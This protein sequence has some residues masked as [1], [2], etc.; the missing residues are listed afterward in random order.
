M[1]VQRLVWAYVYRYEHVTQFW[2]LMDENVCIRVT[3]GCKVW[4]WIH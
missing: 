4:E 1:L 3:T 2:M